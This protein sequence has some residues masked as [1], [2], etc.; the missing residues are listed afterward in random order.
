MDGMAVNYKAPY[1]FTFTP[2]R[3][4]A[5]WHVFRDWEEAGEPGGNPHKYSESTRNLN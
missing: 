5:Q 1:T 4:L 3:N 2:R